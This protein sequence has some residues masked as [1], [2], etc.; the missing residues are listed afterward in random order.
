MTTTDQI[1]EVRPK[2][3]ELR[4]ECKLISGKNKFEHREE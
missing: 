3:S 2:S 1:N 4:T